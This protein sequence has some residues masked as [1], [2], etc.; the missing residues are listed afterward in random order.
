MPAP[1]TSDVLKLYLTALSNDVSKDGAKEI[2]TP[3]LLHAMQARY[4]LCYGPK[5]FRFSKTKSY[6]IA[7]GRSPSQGR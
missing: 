3:D 1:R 6:I 5:G 7:Y 2:R 4:Q